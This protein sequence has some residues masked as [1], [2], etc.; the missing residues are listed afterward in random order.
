M[1][2][3]DVRIYRITG[4]DDLSQAFKLR[5]AVFIDEQGISH[6][7]EF[8]GLD[9]QC[10]HL[11]AKIGERAVGTL[12]I[13]QIDDN[14]AKIERVVVLK[15]ERG[16]HIGINLM[17]AALHQV[18]ELG[19]RTAKIHAQTHAENFYARLGFAPYGDIF[20]EDGIPHIAMQNDVL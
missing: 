11:L 18:R 7:L 5:E 8:D 17:K 12:R 10:E 3:E 19:P 15:S 14:V 2:M 1:T 4:K 20:D 16:R 6:E 13:R 9:D